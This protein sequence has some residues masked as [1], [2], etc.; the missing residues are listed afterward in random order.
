MIGGRSERNGRVTVEREVGFSEPQ[1]LHGL[2][3]GAKLRGIAETA[4]VPS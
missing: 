3:G 4:G 1:S 2:G